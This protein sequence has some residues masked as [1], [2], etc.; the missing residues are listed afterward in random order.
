MAQTK[1]LVDKLL[2]Q[3]SNGY[4]PTG[5]LSEMLLTPITKKE[6]SGLLGK[7]GENHLRIENTIMGGRGEA[8]RIETRKRTTDQF[9]IERHGLEG[10]V[11]EDDRNNEEKPF[12]AERDETIGLSTL[13]WLAK[14]KTLADALTDT[15]TLTQNVTLAG[16]SQFND[17]ANSDPIGRFKTAR[18]TI[19]DSVGIEPDTAVM[20]WKTFN[21]LA[22]HPGILD[23]LG[24]TAN[25]AGQLNELELAKAMGVKRLLIG[26]AQFNSATE[27]QSDA[28]GNVWGKDIV[29]CV[30]PQRT[31][32]YQT[33]IG[34]YIKLKS[35]KPRQV[36]KSPIRNPPRATSIIVEDAY[37]MFL[38]N[39]LAG[40]LIKDAIA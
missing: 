13:L 26:R 18:E 21:T 25:R 1:A 34:Y 8:R 20:N 24:F 30:A 15:A 40:F 36:T 29:Y 32:I 9:V 28:R 33:S 37:D 17:F 31:E 14:E 22:F 19:W 3:V 39:V 11:T 27:G 7:H 16:A 12:D 35:V 4:I 23:A 5:Y 2:T 6:S 38:S 10:V